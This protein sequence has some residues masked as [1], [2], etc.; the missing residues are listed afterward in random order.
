VVE[1]ASGGAELGWGPLASNPS[2]LVPLLHSLL[3]RRAELPSRF[4][5]AHALDKAFFLFS[6]PP[7]DLGSY[8]ML[9]PRALSLLELIISLQLLLL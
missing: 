7:S 2:V 3:V 1:A 5:A 6:L 9:Q 4:P 8:L